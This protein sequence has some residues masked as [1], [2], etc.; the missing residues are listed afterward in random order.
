MAKSIWCRCLKAFAV[1]V[2]GILMSGCS[3]EE[4]IPLKKPDFLLEPSKKPGPDT[5]GDN[6]EGRSARMKPGQ[7][8]G[9]VQ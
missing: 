5:Q 3:G 9:Q 1:A 2:V 7:R 4:T 6:V 8:A